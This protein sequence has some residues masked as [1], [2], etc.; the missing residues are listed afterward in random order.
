MQHHYV[1]QITFLEVPHI[2][3]GARS[4]ECLPEEDAKYLGSPC[5]HKEYWVVNTPVKQILRL[6]EIR[7]DA[8]AYEKMLISQQWEQNK[9]L[10][11]NASIGGE[12]FH[13]A[14]VGHE[15]WNK[16]KPHSPEQIKKIS[17]A[18]KDRIIEHGGKSFV[19]ISPGGEHVFFTNARKFCRDNPEWELHATVICSCAKGKFEQ[20]KG[21]KFFYKEYYESVLEK[22]GVEKLLEDRQEFRNRARQFASI[23]PNGEEFIF[24]NA[25]KF[26]RDN[27]EWN[28]SSSGISN[29]AKG[30][31]QSHKGWRFLYYED[32]MN[33]K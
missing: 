2:Y 20:H 18:L 23:S 5:T 3:F 17:D 21:W 10:S 14:G 29:C 11:L 30:L 9:P 27:P 8:N 26:I 33:A 16:G 24:I 1:Y 15:P 7:D 31:L 19:G 12:K 4:C 13:T 6:F 28:F 25:R 22:Y 32:Y